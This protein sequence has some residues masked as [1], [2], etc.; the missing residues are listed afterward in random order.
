MIE[1]STGPMIQRS[2]HPSAHVVDSWKQLKH[3]MN[4]N[5]SSPYERISVARGELSLVQAALVAQLGTAQPLWHSSYSSSCPIA[6]NRFSSHNLRS[7]T[8]EP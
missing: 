1:R 5:D 3:R 4:L 7:N 6:R 8:V 2:E